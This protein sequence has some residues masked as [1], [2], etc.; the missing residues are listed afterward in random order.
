MQIRDFSVAAWIFYALIALFF[1]YLLFDAFG[2]PVGRTKPEPRQESNKSL[3]DAN[4]Q[5]AGHPVKADQPYKPYAY[6]GQAATDKENGLVLDEK[7]VA[8]DADRSLIEAGLRDVANADNSFD[9]DRFLTNAK[10]TL[11]LM[12]TAF[13]NRD[14]DQLQVLLKDDLYAAFEAAISAAE[15][16][17][18]NAKLDLISIGDPR[19]VDAKMENTVGIVVLLARL[20]QLISKI[21]PDG[22]DVEGLGE[23]VVETAKYTFVRDVNDSKPNWYLQSIEDS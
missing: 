23:T 14:R 5:E 15:D 1:G 12:L 18:D 16:S 4:T 17:G 3:S 6:T 13:Q 2:K 8:L 21:D 20:E 7:L 10:R 9:V 11:E 22:A 19:F